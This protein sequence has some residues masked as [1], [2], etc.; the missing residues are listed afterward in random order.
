MPSPR[1]RTRSDGSVAWQVYFYYYD[2]TGK[3]RQSSETFDEYLPAQQWAELIDTIGVTQ[4]LA[5]LQAQRNRAQVI[6]VVDWLTRYAR[7]RRATRAISE[8]V[9]RKYLGY[10]RNDIAPFYRD[11]PITAVTQDTD[12]AWIVYLEQDKG[13]APKTI[14]N[15]HGFF[16]GGMRAAA[17]QRPEP[18]IA[19]NPCA[20]TRLPVCDIG[21]LDIFDNAEWE[22]FEQLLAPRWRAQAEFGLTSMARPGEVGALRVADIHVGTASAAVRITKAW[23]DC[24]SR[25]TLGAPKTRRGTRTVNIPLRTAARLDLDRDPAD[26]L[27]T[28]GIGTP[29]TAAAFYDGAWIPALRRLAALDAALAAFGDDKPILARSRLAPFGRAARWRGADPEELIAR[30]GPA[31]VS[32]RGKRLTPYTLRH[33]GISWKLQDGV[34]IFVVSRDA[35]HES[36][37]VTDRRYGHNDR[38]ASEKAAS[39][40]AERLPAARADMLAL[41]A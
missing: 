29:V 18:L 35:G 41:A 38:H 10:I 36:T 2:E 4:A 5:V 7:R 23:K 8:P 19:Y 21:E 13:N 14:H 37:L 11:M 15:K 6:S 1:P 32:L 33:T 39:V 34:P 24:G 17:Q 28:T 20:D 9:F 31:I 16:S 27:F 12:A 40:I 22:L 26:L 3:R 25:L 30:F